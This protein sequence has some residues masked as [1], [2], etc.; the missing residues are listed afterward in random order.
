MAC[1]AYLSGQLVFCC[2]EFWDVLGSSLARSSFKAS[3]TSSFRSLASLRF[4]ENS[5]C[6]LRYR[7]METPVDEREASFWVA[8]LIPDLAETWFLLA[9]VV[10]SSLYTSSHFPL[11]CTR[12]RHTSQY[13]HPGIGLTGCHRRWSASWL[14]VW[15]GPGE[16]PRSHSDF[17]SKDRPGQVGGCAGRSP[18][19]A[20]SNARHRLVRLLIHGILGRQ[21]QGEW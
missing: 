7:S 19:T 10:L 12:G 20:N 2:S 11:P 1:S 6:V 21:Y 14:E 16:S 5:S 17:W 8:G 3:S 13:S 9:S 4:M 18:P 15:V